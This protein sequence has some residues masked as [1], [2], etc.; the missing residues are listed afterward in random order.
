M[1]KRILAA[2]LAMM[3]FASTAISASPANFASQQEV[4]QFFELLDSRMEVFLRQ[5]TADFGDR[6]WS[7]SLGR[8]LRWWDSIEEI[9]EH[10]N[11]SGDMLGGF[12]VRMSGLSYV[13]LRHEE[14]LQAE[15]F[16]FGANITRSDVVRIVNFVFGE[17]GRFLSSLAYP[18]IRR[19]EFTVPRVLEVHG[20]NT[21][22]FI[23]I[24]WEAVSRATDE[25]IAHFIETYGDSWL[26]ILI[27]NHVHNWVESIGF[28]GRMDFPM[29]ELMVYALM[30]D[31]LGL[32]RGVEFFHGFTSSSIYFNIWRIFT[33]ETFGDVMLYNPQFIERLTD[34]VE[35]YGVDGFLE[36]L[37]FDMEARPSSKITAFDM[38]MDIH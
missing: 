20:L 9:A 24:F 28:N 31:A 26:Y 30:V 15:T 33:R 8:S 21:N 5:L 6:F 38:G 32:R 36:I 25:D 10:Y 18:G 1:K 29:R 23:N 4:E 22:Q 14:T 35:T 37:D 27:H 13:Q 16:A 34:Y 3:M 7:F 12:G 11:N 19:G 2:L 17:Y